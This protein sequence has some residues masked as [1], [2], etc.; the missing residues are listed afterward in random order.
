MEKGLYKSDSGLVFAQIK[1]S[2]PDGTEVVA[3]EHNGEQG[4]IY[5]GWYWFDSREAAC[6]YFGI[7]EPM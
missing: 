4:E 7:V 3:A 1:V 6:E 2:Y 5:D